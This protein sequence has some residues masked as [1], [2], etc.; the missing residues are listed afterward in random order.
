MHTYC[1]TENSSIF[2]YKK[3]RLKSGKIE[4]LVGPGPK[5]NQRHDEGLTD[6]PRGESQHRSMADQVVVAVRSRPLSSSEKNR[7][8]EDILEFTDDTGTLTLAGDERYPRFTYNFDY[9]Y[10]PKFGQVD[11]YR[12]V[13]APLLRKI[14]DGFNCT[15]FAYGQTGSGK[16]TL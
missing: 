3:R 15:L 12:D 14:M 11:V 9:A 10:S 5:P 7:G 6:G 1:S 4:G 16:R 8:C 13:G 2:G